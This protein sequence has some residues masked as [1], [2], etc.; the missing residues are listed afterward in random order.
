MND[1]T[2][3]TGIVAISF[4]R[5]SSVPGTPCAVFIFKEKNGHHWGRCQ[6]AITGKGVMKMLLYVCLQPL[7][8]LNKYEINIF[9][10]SG[11]FNPKSNYFLIL[12]ISHFALS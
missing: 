12:D 5:I 8:Q 3:N 6:T 9:I 10:R 7:K 1:N 4:S 11:N 2:K